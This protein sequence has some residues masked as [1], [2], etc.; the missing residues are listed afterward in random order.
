MLRELLAVVVIVAAS[1]CATKREWV[2]VGG[3]RADA[4]VK[5]GYDAHGFENPTLDDQQAIRLASQRCA[6]WGYTG[7]A[8]PFA[9]QPPQC[10]FPGP[11]S[12]GGWRITKDFQCLGPGPATAKP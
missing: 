6:A 8:E 2:A 11:V 12:C 4:I 10:L 1:G 5:L 7:G 3:S 9:M